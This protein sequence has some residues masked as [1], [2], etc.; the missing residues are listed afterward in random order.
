MPRSERTLPPSQVETSAG[1]R[2]LAAR[3]RR[4]AAFIPRDEAADRLLEFARE[5]DA[6]AAQLE[7][8]EVKSPT[9][10]G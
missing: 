7:T 8:V 5:L 6:R 9:D 10:P 2:A 1:L 3:A 4:L